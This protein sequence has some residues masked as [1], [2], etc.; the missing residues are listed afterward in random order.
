MH[1]RYE[2]PIRKKTK[3]FSFLSFHLH[4]GFDLEFKGKHPNRNSDGFG[5]E[6]RLKYTDTREKLYPLLNL[7]FR[8]LHDIILNFSTYNQISDS[9]GGMI[10]VFRK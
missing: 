5:S 8:G 2:N 10:E 6:I 7:V 9:E 4:E 1:S 3:Y